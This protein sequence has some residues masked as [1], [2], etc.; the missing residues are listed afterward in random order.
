MA[1]DVASGSNYTTTSKILENQELGVNASGDLY[2]IMAWMNLAELVIIITVSACCY[3][4]TIKRIYL[5][6]FL[7][8]IILQIIALFVLN[9]RIVLLV[10]TMLSR[11]VGM[12]AVTL[13]LIYASLLYPTANRG[14]GVG[15][16]TCVARMGMMLGPFIFETVLVEA[17]FYGIVFNIAVLLMGFTAAMLLPS[18]SVTLD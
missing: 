17:Y 10:V 15:A 2:S 4:I 1:S 13:I 14:I 11:S 7:L 8:S 6:T 18:R 3:F 12:S 16:C 5:T 9:R